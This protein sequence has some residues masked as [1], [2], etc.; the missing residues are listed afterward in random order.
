MYKYLAINIPRITCGGETNL[1]LS[2][3]SWTTD[4]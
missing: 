1:K 2:Y 4:T 3:W